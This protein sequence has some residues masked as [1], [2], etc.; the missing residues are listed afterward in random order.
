MSACYASLDNI[1]TYNRNNKNIITNIIII[2]EKEGRQER[3]SVGYS[4]FAL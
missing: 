1:N 4:A 3:E 2:R